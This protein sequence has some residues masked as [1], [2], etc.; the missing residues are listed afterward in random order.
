M[1]W[2][3]LCTPANPVWVSDLMDSSFLGKLF[4]GGDRRVRACWTN[5]QRVVQSWRIGYMS[6]VS[7]EALDGRFFLM[8]G[9]GSVWAEHS[10]GAF[11][12]SLLGWRLRHKEAQGTQYAVGLEGSPRAPLGLAVS[13]PCLRSAGWLVNSGP[14]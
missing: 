12:V 3:S 7:P 14:G 2:C 10:G 9:W 8:G 11:P 6:Q 1:S 5:T 4:C 13:L